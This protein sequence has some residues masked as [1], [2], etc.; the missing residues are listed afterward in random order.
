MKYVQTN[1]KNISKYFLNQARFYLKELRD[2][3]RYTP[4][5]IY[6]LKVN[7]RNTRKRC[8]IY[9]KLTIKTLERGH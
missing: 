2:T 3:C 5:N 7:N 9:S 1:N 4:A 6:F 8:G